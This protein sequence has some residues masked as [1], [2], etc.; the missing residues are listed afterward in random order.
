MKGFTKIQ[1][2]EISHNDG[3]TIALKRGKI[4]YS[5]NEG[6]LHMPCEDLEEHSVVIYV[7]EIELWADNTKISNTKKKEIVE[8]MKLGMDFLKI[9]CGIDR[10]KY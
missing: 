4:M 9:K 10:K 3:Y 6:I 5:D 8:R 2:S 7:G 1:E